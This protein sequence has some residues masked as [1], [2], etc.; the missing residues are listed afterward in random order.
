[1]SKLTAVIFNSNWVCERIQKYL[2]EVSR[3][4]SAQVG[5]LPC[6]AYSRCTRRAGSYP[7]QGDP[8]ENLE[9]RT[10]L[11]P[12][13]QRNYSSVAEL[14]DKMMDVLEDSRAEKTSEDRI[15]R[16][17]PNQTRQQGRGARE[18]PRT[19]RAHPP[20]CLRFTL[21]LATGEPR[22]HRLCL[23]AKSM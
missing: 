3:K 15:F 19:H 4:G 5:E 6:H 10:R 8:S 9:E 7:K 21:A 12:H 18:R 13:Q 16:I 2:S 1:M 22:V 20:K 17:A 23:P 11:E 14:S